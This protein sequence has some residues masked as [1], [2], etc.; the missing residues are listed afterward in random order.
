MYLCID[1][2]AN[3]ISFGIL[4]GGA[5][6]PCV[7]PKGYPILPVRGA[8]AIGR[9][10]PEVLVTADGYLLIPAQGNFNYF[11]NGRFFQVGALRFNYY[12]NG[13]ILTIGST[14]FDYYDDGRIFTIGP[15]PMSSIGVGYPPSIDY[16]SDGR[17]YSIGSERFNY[18]D[19]GRIFAI[20]PTRF[21]YYDNGRIFA[22]G[23]ER[24]YYND[25]GRI[26]A[27]G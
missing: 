27:I 8:V 15:N 11:D 10:S 4:L 13:R 2:Y 21:N 14:R 26:F 17:V 20:G 7:D 5:Y 24:F 16:F 23:S 18:F 12:D 1:K 19:N 22:I 25:N 3:P 6:F 9:A